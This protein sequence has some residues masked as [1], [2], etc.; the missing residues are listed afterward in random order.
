MSIETC[1]QPDAGWPAATVSYI[2][3]N[4][5]ITL[6]NIDKRLKCFEFLLTQKS[7]LRSNVFLLKKMANHLKMA[8]CPVGGP[9]S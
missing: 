8:F 7:L 4:V 6:V 3:V 5:R 9:L 1:G 2:E